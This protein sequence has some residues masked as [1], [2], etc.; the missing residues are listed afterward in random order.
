MLNS[1]DLLIYVFAG[2][3]VAAILAIALQFITK[4]K[5]IQ[6]IGFYTSSI[7]AA[8]LAFCNLEST[9]IEYMGD[10]VAGFSFAA[11]AIGA[12]VFQFIKKDEKS[13][14]LARILSAVAVLGGMI[15]TFAI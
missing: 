4:N 11:L 12:V 6:N 15:C 2:F 13:F 10:I 7:L 3:A 5:I 9:P 14:K 1:L 8:G